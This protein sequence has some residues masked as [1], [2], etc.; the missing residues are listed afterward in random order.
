MKRLF[1]SLLVLLPLFAGL[2]DAGHDDDKHV[3][4]RPAALK[5]GPNPS[6]PAGAQTAVLIGDPKK[7]GSIYVMRVKL[8]DG[9]KVPPHWHP[10][11]ENV[12]V[13]QGTLLIGAGE[14]FDAS[15]LQEMTAG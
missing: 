14:K 11:D 3:I 7:G 1:P 8:P 9:F 4:V 12:T 6:L 2:A 13:L 15:K 10:H 5:W